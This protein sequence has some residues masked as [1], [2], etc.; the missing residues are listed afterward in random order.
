MVS[1]DQPLI[2][3]LVTD[4]SPT[5]TEPEQIQWLVNGI[6]R[7]QAPF[8]KQVRMLFEKSEPGAHEIRLITKAATPI[9]QQFEQAFWVTLGKAS[10]QIKLE[11]PSAW[12]LSNDKPLVISLGQATDAGE[13]K[14]LHDFEEVGTI[15]KGQTG[16]TG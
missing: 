13:F 14:I 12:E 16:C 8:N 5:A 9:G 4:D 1:E 6:L 7:G 10:E 11:A 2:L 15:S 3:S